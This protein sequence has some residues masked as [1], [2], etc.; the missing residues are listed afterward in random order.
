MRIALILLLAA[1]CSSGSGGG[2]DGGA[3]VDPTRFSGV[4]S[5]T[6]AVTAADGACAGE[7]GTSSTR[8][9]TVSVVESAAGGGRYD[10]SMSGFLG[11]PTKQLSGRVTTWPEVVVSGSYAED[12]GTTTATHTLTVDLPDHVAGT[13]VWSWV[14]PGGTCPNGRSTVTGVRVR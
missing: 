3:P 5:L 10:V 13:E 11:D 9:I 4:W 2:G 12:G 14:G 1:G 7:A 6:L 8:D